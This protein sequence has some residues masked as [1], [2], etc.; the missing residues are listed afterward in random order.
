LIARC[1]PPI[2]FE[3]TPDGLKGAGQ[4]AADIFEEV[5]GG[6]GYRLQLIKDFLA[7]TDEALTLDAFRRS[8]QYPATARNYVAAPPDYKHPAVGG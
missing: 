8:M 4:T 1:K 3:C 2:L 6:L 5:T 7:G